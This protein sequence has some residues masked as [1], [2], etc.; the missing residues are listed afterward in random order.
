[1]NEKFL[2]LAKYEEQ[3]LEKLSEVRIELTAVMSDLKEGT[4]LQDLT[5]LAVYKI[6]KP[7]GVFTHFRDLDYVRTSLEGET[8]GSLS[9]KEAESLGFSLKI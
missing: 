9:K 7:K 8:R 3:L 5:T 1:M 6:I 4:Y 2:T